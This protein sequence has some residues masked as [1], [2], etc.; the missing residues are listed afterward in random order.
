MKNL[1]NKYCIFRPIPITDLDAV[2]GITRKIYSDGIKLPMTKD[3]P[4]NQKRVTARL[5]MDPFTYHIP[6]GSVKGQS[7]APVA[8]WSHI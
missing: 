5:I 2:V 4:K 7:S 6:K 1:R 3:D 8:F